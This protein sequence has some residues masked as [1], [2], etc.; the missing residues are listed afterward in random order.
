MTHIHSSSHEL[1]APSLQKTKMPT[2]KTQSKPTPNH[3]TKNTHTQTNTCHT[4]DS[5]FL[6]YTRRVNR[7]I[8]FVRM[9]KNRCTT[10]R[11]MRVSSP[12]ITKCTRRNKACLRNSLWAFKSAFYKPN[13]GGGPPAAAGAV[14]ASHSR[15]SHTMTM[16]PHCHRYVKINN[17]SSSFRRFNTILYIFDRWWCF[18]E[19]WFIRSILNWR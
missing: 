3:K 10:V 11:V 5:S 4:Y 9:F 18:R 17:R 13:K 12:P 16:P 6:I 7:E 1:L 15:G 2:Q 14:C 19:Y 8:V